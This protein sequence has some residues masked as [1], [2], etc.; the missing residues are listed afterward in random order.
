MAQKRSRHGL[1]AL[2]AR[3]SVRGLG[4]VDM[5]TSAARTLFAW[6]EELLRDLGR[7]LPAQKIALVE[8]AVRTRLYIEHLD[9]FLMSQPS[10]VNRRRKSVIPALR[11]RMSLVD[12][13]GRI[14]SQLGLERVPKP[15]PSL[16]A[17]LAS[18]GNESDE[19]EVDA[20]PEPESEPSS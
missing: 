1:H 16:A 2:K 20:E 5:R 19:P 3:V 7:D 9:A 11:E 6:K 15:V 17:Y 8:L 4:A 13:L 14:L 12:S 10:L 18:R